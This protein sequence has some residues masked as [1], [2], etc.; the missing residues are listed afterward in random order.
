MEDRFL[1]FYSTAANVSFILLGFWWAVVSLKRDYW[2][3]DPIRRRIGYFTSLHFVVM[4]ISS[5]IS[6]LSAQDALIWRAGYGLG[7]VIGVI[8]ALMVSE[9]SRRAVGASRVPLYVQGWR[10]LAVLYVATVVI[11]VG[12]PELVENM[13]FGVR[14]I[15]IEAVLTGLLLFLGAQVTWALFVVSWEPPS[16][17]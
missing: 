12:G 9:N 7:G 10:V 1:Y 16:S 4:G 11:A 8:A 14:A 13:G 15:E 6:L 2:T 5:L 17:E 3:A